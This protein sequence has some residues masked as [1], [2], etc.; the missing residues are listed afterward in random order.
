MRG[1]LAETARGFVRD[2]QVGEE[3]EDILMLIN[4]V[5]LL[6]RS[7]GK[8][9]DAE[10][11][12]RQALT[13]IERITFKNGGERKKMLVKIKEA[14]SRLKRIQKQKKEYLQIQMDT[15]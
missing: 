10:V 6:F 5:A 9:D 12:Y 13:G 14:E 11:L 4:R 7:L 2:V 3:Q 8:L 1:W 15:R